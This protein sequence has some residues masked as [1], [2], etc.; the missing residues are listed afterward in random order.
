VVRRRVRGRSCPGCDA[1][2]LLPQVLAQQ[3]A[4]ARIEQAHVNARP[5]APGR[6]ADPARRRAVV[7]GLDFHAA[8]QV[9]PALA[10]L[11]M[12]KGSTGSGS[13]AGFSSANMAA[14]WRL[15]VPW[16]RVSA[17]LLFPAVEVGL[18][19]GEALEAQPFERGV[20]GMADAALDLALAIRIAHAAGQRD[21]A[22]VREQVAV[23]RIQRRVVDVGLQH[24]F[25]EI[26]EDTRCA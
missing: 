7:S 10:E 23:E 18:G 11:I 15:V 5:T 19:F 24:A 17:Q 13:S 14:T 12:R 2:A 3:L 16:M 9:H 8:V 21:G 20:L 6:A 4:G 1:A 26:V 22:V 25:A